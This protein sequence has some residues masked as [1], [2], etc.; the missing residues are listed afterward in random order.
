MGMDIG[1]PLAN[2]IYRTSHITNEMYTTCHR[3]V[4]SNPFKKNNIQARDLL[5]LLKPGSTANKECGHEKMY[6]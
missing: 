1:K 3:N 6:I 4:R 5:K 2:E